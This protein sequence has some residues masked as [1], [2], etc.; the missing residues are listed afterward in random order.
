M[1]SELIVPLEIKAALSLVRF[2]VL[3][4]SAMQLAAL[5]LIT[6]GFMSLLTPG[7]QIED[8]NGDGIVSVEE[9]QAGVQSFFCGESEE[10]LTDEGNLNTPQI[11]ANS[12]SDV[13]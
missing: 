3:K 2:P 10:S 13:P 11:D 6:I 8:T 4:G 9:I 12:A 5:K 7:C 1:K